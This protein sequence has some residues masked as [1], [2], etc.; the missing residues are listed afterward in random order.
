MPKSSKSKANSDSTDG[1]GLGAGTSATTTSND[2]SEEPSTSASSASSAKSPPMDPALL[3]SMM[4]AMANMGG[5]P[6]TINEAS[7]REY[8]FWETQPVPKIHEKVEHLV[9]ESIEPE[10]K[11][12][13]LKREPYSLPEGFEWKTLD[14]DDSDVVSIR[15]FDTL[16]TKWSFD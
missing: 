2:H 9:N 15:R 4:Q 7:Q 6:K 10:K 13:E 3:A 8:K 12:E 11:P 1:E 5:T 16:I 14:I